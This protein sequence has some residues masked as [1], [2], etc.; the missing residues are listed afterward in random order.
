[1]LCFAIASQQLSDGFI[2]YFPANL[3]N[4]VFSLIGAFIGVRVIT[5][6]ISL[7]S[8]RFRVWYNA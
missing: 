3:S 2:N 1:L 6:G 4:F 5:V 7:L 8:P